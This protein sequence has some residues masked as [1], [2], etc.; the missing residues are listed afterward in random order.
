MLASLQSAGSGPDSLRLYKS[1]AVSPRSLV[2]LITLWREIL[3]LPSSL[4]SDRMSHQ[5]GLDRTGSGE[6]GER[7]CGLPLGGA[8][9]DKGAEG[10]Q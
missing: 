8:G 9:S 1:S 6:A 3:A 2:S 4:E 7:L 10:G 5:G